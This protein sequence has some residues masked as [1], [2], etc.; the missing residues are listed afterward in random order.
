MKPKYK[1]GDVLRVIRHHVGTDTGSSPRDNFVVR[2][3]DNGQMPIYFPKDNRQG[4]YEDQLIPQ[5]IDNWKTLMEDK[6]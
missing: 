3:I 1:V 4:A 5:T 2:S 6:E